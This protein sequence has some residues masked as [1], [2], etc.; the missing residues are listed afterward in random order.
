[1]KNYT[2]SNCSFIS[3]VSCYIFVVLLLYNA[4]FI[5][6]PFSRLKWCIDYQWGAKSCPWWHC[7]VQWCQMT[8]YSL[9]PHPFLY[10]YIHIFPSSSKYSHLPHS[11]FTSLRPVT[12]ACLMAGVWGD[13]VLNFMKHKYL[14]LCFPG[15]KNAPNSFWCETLRKPM[16]IS[17]GCT[18]QWRPL[19]ELGCVL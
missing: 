12:E 6:L 4:Y 5:M 13:E 11:F 9:L 1:M 7:W 15:K 14:F 17:K 18:W 10:I 19:R 16:E 2:G 3:N 8:K